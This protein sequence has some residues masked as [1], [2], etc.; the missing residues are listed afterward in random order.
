MLQEI[1]TAFQ[2]IMDM[3]KSLKDE[4]QELQMS[5]SRAANDLRKKM[6]ELEKE[7]HSQSFHIV[8]L[9]EQSENFQQKLNELTVKKIQLE[10]EIINLRQD[11]L[12]KK[13]IK[14]GP[15]ASASSSTDFGEEIRKK[16]QML[17][18]AKEKILVIQREE[19]HLAARIR[20]EEEEMGENTVKMANMRDDLKSLV[21][22]QGAVTRTSAIGVQLKALIGEQQ[23]RINRFAWLEIKLASINH[24]IHLDEILREKERWLDH[25]MDYDVE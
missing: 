4:T 13:K 20:G 12:G 24:R 1:Q 2:I 22:N 23:I 8:V 6:E 10:Q 3:K 16:K 5:R 25:L 9:K 7:V 17:K 18:D 19:I 11:S 15:I 21:G 14:L